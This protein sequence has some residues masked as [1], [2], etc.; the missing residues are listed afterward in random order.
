M[1]YTQNLGQINR[2]KVESNAAYI[3]RTSIITPNGAQM[4]E[5]VTP[6][7][8]KVKG[9]EPTT[10]YPNATVYPKKNQ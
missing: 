4:W 10:S 6:S 9:Y 1:E 7:G 8:V 2:I 5:G 3:N